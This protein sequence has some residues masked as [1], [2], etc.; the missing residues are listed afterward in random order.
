MAAFPG[1]PGGTNPLSRN[2]LNE[3]FKYLE[4]SIENPVDGMYDS[5]RAMNT[6]KRKIYTV[7]FDA[8]PSADITLITNHYESVG[9][10]ESFTWVDKDATSHTVTYAEPPEIGFVVNGYHSI[11]ALQF[12][13]V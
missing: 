3:S 2:P 10:S 6:R 9:V 11:A 8:L 1:R 13:E 7:T 5:T 4:P 12:K